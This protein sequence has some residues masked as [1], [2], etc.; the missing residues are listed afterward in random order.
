M[1]T[2]AQFQLSE[3]IASVNVEKWLLLFLR[4]RGL[5]ALS[6]GKTSVVAL[7][8]LAAFALA[9]LKLTECICS[10]FY[11]FNFEYQTAAFVNVENTIV[12]VRTF[13]VV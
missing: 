8:I 12:A 10:A 6:E 3:P 1:C 13:C 5:S 7:V 4:K 9:A 11:S 2:C